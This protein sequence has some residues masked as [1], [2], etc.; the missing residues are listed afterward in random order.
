MKKKPDFL[1]YFKPHLKKIYEDKE[2][3]QNFSM[4]T[5]GL[6]KNNLSKQERKTATDTKHSNFSFEDTKQIH[7]GSLKVNKS[8][9]SAS[10]QNFRPVKMQIHTFHC[11]LD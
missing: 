6:Q 1:K 9:H 7:K 5:Y 2:N 4:M 8:V 3:D 10:L 11:D